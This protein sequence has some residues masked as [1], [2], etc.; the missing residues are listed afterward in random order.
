MPISK[1]KN[2]IILILGVCVLALLLQVVPVRLE[3]AR[4]EQELYVR[5]EEL[6]ASYD[7]ALEGADLPSSVK[8]YAIEL[9]GREEGGLQAAQ[10]LLGPD[11]AVEDDSTRFSTLYT[12]SA[13]SCTT[14][15][16]GAFHAELTG[17]G[18]LLDQNRAVDLLKEV[19]FD[20]H[21]LTAEVPGEMQATQTLLGVPVFSD[22]LRL[23]Y[24]DGTL[25]VLDGTFFV[26]AQQI[27]RISEEACVSCADALVALLSS[28]DALGWMGSRIDTVTQGYRYAESATTTLRLTPVWRIQ[29]DTGGFEVDG[30]SGQVSP[31]TSQIPAA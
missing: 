5:L 24:S 3:Q 1:L 19:G 14:T 9:T 8:L 6:Y 27:T 31:M 7:V 23:S 22:G 20:V 21:T 16:N 17:D 13:G 10:A 25:R 28:R 2:L 26:G 18:R 11:V 29:T 30:L 15:L 4:S 12:S